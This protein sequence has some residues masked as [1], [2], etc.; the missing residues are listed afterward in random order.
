LSLKSLCAHEFLLVTICIHIPIHHFFSFI[1]V[2]FFAVHVLHLIFKLF[3]G[4]VSWLLL[5]VFLL[6]N[7]HVLLVG[8]HL[9][10]KLLVLFFIQFIHVFFAFTF[11]EFL[12]F[13]VYFVIVFTALLPLCGHHLLNL[14]VSLVDIFLVAI[15]S[16]L[17][18]CWRVFLLLL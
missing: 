6:I 9:H 3:S 2:F 15:V 1:F 7:Q 17:I 14:L 10:Q 8:L 11:V 5:S 12:A 18:S 13:I 4:N 16:H